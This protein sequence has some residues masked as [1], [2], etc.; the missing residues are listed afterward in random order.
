M[1]SGSGEMPGGPVDPRLWSRPKGHEDHN[2]V[3]IVTVKVPLL[4]S[5]LQTSHKEKHLLA[6]PIIISANPNELGSNDSPDVVEVIWEMESLQ[7][8]ACRAGR[9]KSGDRALLTPFLAACRPCKA[10]PS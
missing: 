3:G 5:Q 4:H 9:G 1:D 8:G 7:C 2:V 6:G 10:I